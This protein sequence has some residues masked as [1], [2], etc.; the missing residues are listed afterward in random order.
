MHRCHTYAQRHKPRPTR[1]RARNP[2]YESISWYQEKANRV[3]YLVIYV[4]PYPLWRWSTPTDHECQEHCTVWRQLCLPLLPWSILCLQPTGKEWNWI[5]HLYVK[6]LWPLYTPNTWN[7][8]TAT[9]Q[10]FPVG[11]N[12]NLSNSLQADKQMKTSCY[13]SGEKSKK[14]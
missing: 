2:C 6:L 8:C 5:L 13:V 12:W 14:I 9:L 11:I 4:L 10:K 1:M 3:I 7:C